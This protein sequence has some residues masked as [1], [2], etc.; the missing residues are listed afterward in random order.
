MGR[1][2]V[3]GGG[4]A[5]VCC[6]RGLAEA[7]AEVVLF[8]AAGEVGGRLAQCRR[9]RAVFDHGAQYARGRDPVFV[10][11][12]EAG[13]AAGI[14]TRW[15]AAE[16]AVRPVYIGRPA[17]ATPLQVMVAELDARTNCRIVRL[18][19]TGA[20]WSLEDAQGGAHGPFER[21]ALAVTP[22]ALR[23]LL[24]NSGEDAP[25]RLVAASS[26]VRVAPCWTLLLAFA[27][28]LAIDGPEV[29]RLAEGSIA[30]FARN[31]TKPGREGLD[32]WTVHASAEWSACHAATPPET[33]AAVLEEAFCALT[34]SGHAPPLHAETVF[35]PEA[36]VVEALGRDAL[37]DAESGL[38]VCGDWCI[39]GR[40]EAAF[41]SGRARVRLMRR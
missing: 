13:V 28:P 31:P 29:R 1:L 12:L 20:G 33:V 34:G 37:F 36:L 14:V 15:R 16:G 25:A 9:D 40:I 38:G 35:W 17:M 32:S 18:R 4:V 19:R 5:G 7:G 10:K 21:V 39:G 27:Q 3:I 6:A 11:L 23:A 22:L 26:R 41:L 30:W 2:A 8:E 24:A